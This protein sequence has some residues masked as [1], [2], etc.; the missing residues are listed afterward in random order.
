MGRGGGGLGGCHGTVRGNAAPPRRGKDG[1]G[2][3]NPKFLSWDCGGG[4]GGG[5]GDGGVELG[6]TMGTAD[7]L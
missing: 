5:G 6:G 2:L 1:E 4:W 7:T 3:Y